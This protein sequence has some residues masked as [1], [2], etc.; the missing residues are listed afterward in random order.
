[1]ITEKTQAIISLTSHK[2]RIKLVHYAIFSAIRNC[3]EICH[4]VLTISKENLNYLEG[5]IK[6][7]IENNLVELLVVD[8]DLG[9]HTKY[10]YCMKKYRNL[11]IITIDDDQ[12]YFADTIPNLLKKYKEHK[13]CV[14][15]R[16][17]RTL[18]YKDNKILPF[19]VWGDKVQCCFNEG[20]SKTNHCMGTGAILYPPNILNISDELLPEIRKY[21]KADDIYLNALELRYNVKVYCFPDFKN[22]KVNEWDEWQHKNKDMTSIALREETNRLEISD[23][24]V[25]ELEK[26]FNK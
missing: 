10:F 20:I 22:G 15:G 26:D 18:K 16:M 25:K 2:S 21:R 5:P 23:Y 8:E 17:V 11:P 3:K 1:M 13:D 4:V 12:R 9:P 6:D 14:I 19:S 24:Y 7:L